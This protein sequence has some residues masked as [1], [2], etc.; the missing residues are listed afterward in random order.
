MPDYGKIAYEAYCQCSGGKSLVSGA[1][2]PP[3]EELSPEIRRA[4]EW[5]ADA[6]LDA[7]SEDEL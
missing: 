3:W 5:A 6:V 4:W 1:K 7:D 2:L